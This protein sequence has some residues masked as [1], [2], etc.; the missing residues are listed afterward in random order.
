[1]L[2]LIKLDFELHFHGH[3]VNFFLGK[4]YYSCGY[5]VN[6]FIVMILNIV[7]IMFVFLILH[8]LLIKI[9]M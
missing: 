7:K 4:E 1:M 8:K 9:M 5:F 2:V 6:V 3:Y